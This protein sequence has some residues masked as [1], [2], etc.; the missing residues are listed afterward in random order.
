VLTD[1]SA[2]AS[3]VSTFSSSSNLR[4]AAAGVAVG[5]SVIS[6]MAAVAAVNA[7]SNADTRYWRNLPNAVHVATLK[8]KPGRHT[9]NARFLDK[10]GRELPRYS[11]DITVTIKARGPSLIWIRSRPNLVSGKS[12]PLL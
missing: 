9:L 1:A 8:L 5:L 12:R 4:D 7:R 6:A 10:A 11:K 3:T 2:V